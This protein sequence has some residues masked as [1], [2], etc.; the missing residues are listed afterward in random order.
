MSGYLCVMVGVVDVP[1]MSISGGDARPGDQVLGWLA[2]YPRGGMAAR[3]R[4]GDVSQCAGL[5]AVRGFGVDALALRLSAIG[6]RY[7]TASSVPLR[8]VRAAHRGDRAIVGPS[9][10]DDSNPLAWDPW[11]TRQNPPPCTPRP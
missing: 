10:P 5:L 8:R 1:A 9:G 2:R 7:A 4:A 6:A 11:L 3:R